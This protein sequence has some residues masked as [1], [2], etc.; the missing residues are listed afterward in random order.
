MMPLS[1][2]GYDMSYT[3]D[4]SSQRFGRKSLIHRLFNRKRHRKALDP[5]TLFQEKVRPERRRERRQRVLYAIVRGIVAF[6][7]GLLVALALSHGSFL[8]PSSS[9]VS[10][11]KSAAPTVTQSG[12]Q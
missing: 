2:R 4:R 10:Y 12:S 1:Y 3:T 8:A 6:V 9:N 5:Y 7:L 11:D